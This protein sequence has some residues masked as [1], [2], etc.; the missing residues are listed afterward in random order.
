ML[1]FLPISSNRLVVVLDPPVLGERQAKSPHKMSILIEL[2]L[3][4]LP[5]HLRDVSSQ[6]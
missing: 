2:T 3:G 5:Y 6:L 1:S 4:H